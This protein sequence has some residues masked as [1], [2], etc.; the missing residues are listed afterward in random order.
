MPFQALMF[1]PMGIS[2][3]LV[4]SLLLLGAKRIPDIASL[5]GKAIKEFWL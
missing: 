5:L 1:D 4:V 3:L 2:L